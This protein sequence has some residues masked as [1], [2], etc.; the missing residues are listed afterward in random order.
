M[1]SAHL[2][3]ARLNWA[4]IKQ[5]LADKDVVLQELPELPQWYPLFKDGEDLNRRLHRLLG[6][7]ASAMGERLLDWQELKTTGTWLGFA[8]PL[9]DVERFSSERLQLTVDK[10]THQRNHFRWREYLEA[11]GNEAWRVKEVSVVLIGLWAYLAEYNYFLRQSRGKGLPLEQVLQSMPEEG[12]FSNR[13]P[14]AQCIQL[15]FLRCRQPFAQYYD[16]REFD[17]LRAAAHPGVKDFFTK[18]LPVIDRFFRGSTNSGEDKKLAEAFYACC[19]TDLPFVVLQKEA[20]GKG[21]AS[22]AGPRPRLRE[23]LRNLA[24]RLGLLERIR[25]VGSS[26]PAAAPK[27]APA[28]SPLIGG[29]EANWTKFSTEAL[30]AALAK[31][32]AK[33]ERAATGLWEEQLWRYAE[34]LTAPVIRW[35]LTKGAIFPA[36]NLLPAER[37]QRALEA[38][39][40]EQEL[41]S[42]ELEQ[43]DAMLFRLYGIK[44]LFQIQKLEQKMPHFKT[45]AAALRWEEAKRTQKK[46]LNSQD[47]YRAQR[48]VE[49]GINESGLNKHKNEIW[50]DELLKIEEEV[51]PFMAYVSRAFQAALPVGTTLEFNPYRHRHDGIEFDPETIQDPAKWLRG[52]VMKTLRSRK[53]FAPITQ[54]NTFCLDY[55]RSMT[56]ELMRDLFKT[57]FLLVMGLES[58]KT[59]DAIHFF[60][61]GFHEVAGFENN[62]SFT[63]RKILFRVLRNIAQQGGGVVTY[64]GIGGTNISAGVSESHQ[65]LLAFMK[66]LKEEDPEAN[67][68]ASIF[69]LTDGQPTMGIVDLPE[70]HDLIQKKREDGNV[71]IKGIFLNPPDEAPWTLDPFEQKRQAQI[72]GDTSN[73][74]PSSFIRKIFG[75]QNAVTAT[76]FEDTVTTF[77]QVMSKTY[78]E[79]RR[80]FREEEKRRKIQSG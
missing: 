2:S 76:T 11:I 18:Q 9:A 29:K 57:V 41:I 7:R 44:S 21:R 62:D 45:A 67:V 74:D 36:W 35:E 53:D 14:S 6:E 34:Q 10:I 50:L 23:R 46:R 24:T 39:W 69:V 79:Q 15:L 16:G 75:P 60:G 49:F 55:S 58:R 40:S 78:R 27:M 3:I 30:E 48:M 52:E 72:Y 56:H 71:A 43:L 59:Y 5:D 66:E 17:R 68:V 26:A 20:I 37:A 51:R 61:S 13:L 4:R 63:D 77:V 31:V 73:V 19:R 28:Y 8:V 33:E 54:V 1:P 70:L 64:G 65:R 32:S 42:K 25:S 12:P 47:H 22:G 80:K 38:H